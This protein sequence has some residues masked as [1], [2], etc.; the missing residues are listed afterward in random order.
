MNVVSCKIMK[1]LNVGIICLF[2]FLIS[3]ILKSMCF[4]F[5]L[6]VN[7][8]LSVSECNHVSERL[9]YSL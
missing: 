2:L 3:K 6:L 5:L 1:F 7:I 4:I 9:Y 8:Y